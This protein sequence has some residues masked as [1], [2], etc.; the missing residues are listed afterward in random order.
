MPICNCQSAPLPQLF[1]AWINLQQ[2]HAAIST[3][4]QFSFRLETKG[5]MVLFGQAIDKREST[6]K[7]VFGDRWGHSAVAAYLPQASSFGSRAAGLLQPSCGCLRHQ[8]SHSWQVQ[9]HCCWH[10][11][12]LQHLQWQGSPAQTHHPDIILICTQT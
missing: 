3:S 11:C 2:M 8:A 12:Q 9:R 10:G 1:T 6:V 5:G 4:A 7:N